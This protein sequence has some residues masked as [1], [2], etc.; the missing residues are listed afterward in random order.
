MEISRILI[1]YA[2]SIPV[3]F[4]IDMV[5]LGVIA[6]NFYRKSLESLLTPNV[7]WTA[8]LIFYFIFLAGILIF[9]LIPGIE[10]KSLAYTV[11]MAAVFGF[12]AYATY[13]LTNLATLRDWP[14][15]ISI[16]DMCWGAF[17]SASTAAIT[18]MI[19]KLI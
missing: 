15:M 11:K 4:A 18:Y 9:A 1:T 3:F 16:V 7:N 12:I 5:W 8:A 19:M 10:K 14:L 6:K 13:D 17:L 2:V